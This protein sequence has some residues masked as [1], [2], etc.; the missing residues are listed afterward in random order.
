[1]RVAILGIYHESNTFITTATTLADFK[2]SHWL[3]G[4]AIIQEYAN[5]HHEIGGMLQTLRENNIK[6]VPVMFAETTP[7]GIISNEAYQILLSE[8]L[9]GLEQQLPID[10]CLV[11]PHGAAVSALH[12]DMDGH[13]L[14]MIRQLLG[15]GIPIVGTLDPHA[16]ISSLMVEST[17]ALVAY[18]TNPHLDQ[19]DAGRTAGMLMCSILLQKKRLHQVLIQSSVAISIEQQNTSVSPCRELYNLSDMLAA[20]EGVWVTNIILGFP[21]ADVYEMGSSFLVVAENEGLAKQTAQSLQEYV[22]ENKAL[23]EGE[24]HTIDQLLPR[25]KAAEKPILLL[26]MGDNVGAG[27]P[28]NSVHLL[29][30]LERSGAYISFCCIYDPAAV[31]FLMQYTPGSSVYLQ[32]GSR[33]KNHETECFSGKVTL[34]TITEGKFK[35]SNP[36]HGGQVNYDMGT[37]AILKTQSGNTVMIHSLRVPPFSLSQLTNFGILPENFDIIVAKGVNAPIAAYG[38]VCRSIFQVNTPGVTQADMTQFSFK[39]RRKPLFPFER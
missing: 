1:M 7:G 17:D 16:N 31:R 15:P 26:D 27:A 19:R 9:T 11:A 12:P 25:M 6:T 3:K 2:N 24:K 18:K 36:R 8:M 20:Q 21:Y 29:N 4:D 39:H 35:E 28:G 30:A 32:T 23:F 14:S 13:W 34:L 33:E 5:A 10:G 22:E 38:P 37:M